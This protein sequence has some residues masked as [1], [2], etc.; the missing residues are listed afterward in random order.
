MIKLLPDDRLSVLRRSLL[1]RLSEQRHM[2]E[3]ELVIFGLKYL[4]Q[5]ASD[6]S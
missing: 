3:D 1:E 6:A 2:S 5:E 4:H